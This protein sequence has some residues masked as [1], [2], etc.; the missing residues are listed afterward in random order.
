MMTL[1]LACF[2]VG[3]AKDKY[4]NEIEPNGEYYTEGLIT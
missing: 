1:S 2:N 4:G 3:K